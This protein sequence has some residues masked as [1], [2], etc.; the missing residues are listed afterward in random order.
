MEYNAPDA[1]ILQPTGVKVKL[2]ADS[3]AKIA[4]LARA[5]TLT[6]QAP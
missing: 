5:D 6:T 3:D 4:W 2:E 1:L